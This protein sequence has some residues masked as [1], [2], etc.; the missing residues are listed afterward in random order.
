VGIDAAVERVLGAFQDAL[1]C[2][3]PQIR[4]S[5]VPHEDSCL[6]LTFSTSLSLSRPHHP[7][8]MISVGSPAIWTAT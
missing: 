6:F 4:T 1:A 2:V 7:S 3:S 5:R 8:A